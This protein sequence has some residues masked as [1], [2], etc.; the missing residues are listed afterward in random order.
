MIEIFCGAVRSGRRPRLVTR[1][2]VLEPKVAADESQTLVAGAQT[3]SLAFLFRV[4]VCFYLPPTAPSSIRSAFT[5]AL[6]VLPLRRT[7][8]GHGYTLREPPTTT[9][10]V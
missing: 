9:A 7:I 1:R 10:T 5:A 6:T 2:Y 4:I 8:S 3:S